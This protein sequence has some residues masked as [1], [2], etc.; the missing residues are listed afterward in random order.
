[1]SDDRSPGAVH[2]PLLIGEAFG[3]VEVPLPALPDGVVALTVPRAGPEGDRV[4]L[5]RKGRIRVAEVDLVAGASVEAFLPPATLTSRELAWVLE[6]GSTRRWS[7][8][9]AKLGDRAWPVSV[10][11]IRA[12]GVVVRCR[13]DVLAY[14]P[15]S[16]RLS[17]AWASQADDLLQEMRGRVPPDVA[18]ADLLTAISGVPQLAD[19]HA[20]LAAIDEGTPLRVP[21]GS[22]T[23]AGTWPVYEAALRAASFWWPAQVP[24]QRRL[25]MRE[26]AGKALGGSKKWTPARQQAFENLVDLPFD[27]AVD[28]AEYEIR[29][30]GPLR[31]FV[32]S[33]A[34][35][36]SIGRPWI[37]LPSDGV[38]LVGRIERNAHGVLVVENSDTFKQICIIPAVTERWLCVWGKGTVADGV[39]AF[40]KSMH[41]IPIAAWCDLDAY[42]IRILGDLARR[43]E[44]DITP[45]G[46]TPDLYLNGTKYRPEDLAESQRIAAKM[47]DE[48]PLSLRDLAAMIARSEGLGC[49][50]ET[51]YDEVLPTL[52]GQLRQLEHSEST[53]R[54]NE[55]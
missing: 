19:E 30:A 14:H 41:D 17:H 50:Q 8:V 9:E 34:A 1:M 49:E 54:S 4:P 35:D 7:T 28:K 46:M 16:W 38:R 43:V 32:G 36:A 10:D 33:V 2:V 24:G 55:R 3:R 11:L 22:R 51:L 52:A 12:G 26:L 13:V 29:V 15:H 6:T 25:T 48:G 45:V 23:R 31:W 20:L 27:E 47:A 39:V 44:R 37:G 21:V 5:D 53:P 18:R 42:G 40:L